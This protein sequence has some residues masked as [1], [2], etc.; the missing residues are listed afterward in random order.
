MLIPMGRI[1]EKCAQINIRPFSSD[2]GAMSSVL[3]PEKFLL[4]QL[5][6]LDSLPWLSY[7][8]GIKH[9]SCHLHI[10]CTSNQ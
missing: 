5:M 1:D 10:T 6:A 4:I 8:F 3:T 9:V 2:I 7:D